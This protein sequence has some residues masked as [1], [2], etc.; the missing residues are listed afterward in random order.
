MSQVFNVYCDE[1]C[2]LENDRQKVMVLGAVWC[3]LKKARDIAISIR[4]IKAHHNMRPGFEIK[5]TKVSTGKLDF[6]KELVDF[7]FDT[8]YL[9][10]RAWIIPD[11]SILKHDK[12][13]QSHD[14]WYY[15]MYFYLLRNIISSGKRGKSISRR[16]HTCG[17]L[18]QSVLCCWSRYGWQRDR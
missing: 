6:Y 18:N 3:P 12:Y 1:S 8:P 10:F 15:K 2:H 4:E 9:N 11:K 16:G 17:R 14:D 5:W 7:F 13:S